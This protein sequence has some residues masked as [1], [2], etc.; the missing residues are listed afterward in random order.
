MI[1][2]DKKK[3][4]KWSGVQFTFDLRPAWPLAG[5]GLRL[6]LFICVF[7]GAGGYMFCLDY[8]LDTQLQLSDVELIS[9]C[10]IHTKGADEAA[11]INVIAA[12]L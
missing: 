10:V 3:E 11:E 7:G 8:I 9:S 2:P 1:G 4:G 5:P 6:D 12:F